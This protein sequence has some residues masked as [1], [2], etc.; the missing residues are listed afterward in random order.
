M[1]RIGLGA[2]LTLAIVGGLVAIQGLGLAAVLW[3]RE[4]DGAACFAYA[5]DGYSQRSCFTVRREGSNYRFDQFVMRH[6]ER[7][8]RRCEGG[9]GLVSQGPSAPARGS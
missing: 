2:R 3:L 1:M 7:G 5:D 9:A 4:P 8:V 6:I